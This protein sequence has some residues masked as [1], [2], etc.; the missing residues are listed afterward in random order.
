[1]YKLEDASKLH[2][3]LSGKAIVDDKGNWLTTYEDYSDFPQDHKDFIDRELSCVNALQGIPAESLGE[4]K[5]AWLVSECCRLRGMYIRPIAGGT[6][7]VEAT[8]TTNLAGESYLLKGKSWTQSPE[9]E[10]EKWQWYRRNYAEKLLQTPVDEGYR[11]FSFLGW[12]TPTGE[13]NALLD[14]VKEER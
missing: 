7:L 13:L 11:C 12:I 6:W 5:R 4:A 10:L 3:E 9:S 14:S 2:H 8:S 1:M